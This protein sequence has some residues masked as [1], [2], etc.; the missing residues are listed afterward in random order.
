MSGTAGATSSYLAPLFKA[1]VKPPISDMHVHHMHRRLEVFT[2]VI[3]GEH[4]CIPTALEQFLARYM[5][6]GSTLTRLEMR[7]PDPAQSARKTSSN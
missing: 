5:P 4:H 3:F 6:M 7:Q 1:K 2:K